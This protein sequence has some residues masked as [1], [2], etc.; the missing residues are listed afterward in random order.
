MGMEDFRVFEI[1]PIFNE[2]V[3]SGTPIVSSVTGSSITIDMGISSLRGTVSMN[4]AANFYVS[5]TDPDGDPLARQDV[6]DGDPLIANAPRNFQFSVRAGYV[7]DFE[8]GG[9]SGA[10]VNKLFIEQIGGP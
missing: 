3:A 1:T 10:T 2:S 4:A 6:F 7:Y 9:V 8:Y 5:E